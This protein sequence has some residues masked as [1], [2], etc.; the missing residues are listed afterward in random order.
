M[1]FGKKS[2]QRCPCIP[3]RNQ[4]CLAA[5]AVL[6]F[7]CTAGTIA[8]HADVMYWPSYT[9]NVDACNNNYYGGCAPGENDPA[10]YN[11][12]AMS[13]NSN[14]TMETISYGGLIPS[15]LD[16]EVQGYQINNAFSIP[17]QPTGGMLMGLLDYLPSDGADY[18]GEE[19]VVLFVN[20]AALTTSF[21]SSTWDQ[22]FN[23]NPGNPGSFSE[24]QIVNDLNNLGDFNSLLNLFSFESFNSDLF[25]APDGGTFDAV[26]F[27]SPTQIGSGS[28]TVAVTG[29]TTPEPATWILAGGAL[30]VLVWRRKRAFAS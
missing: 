25:F 16:A 10:I 11:L 12:I 17:Y 22:L 23:T 1:V 4:S 27:S 20:P 15:F 26:A 3:R 19:H 18:P 29:N 6:V 2:S 13:A 7:A 30:A 14:L 9:L 24:D 5:L 8:G 28:A 21:M